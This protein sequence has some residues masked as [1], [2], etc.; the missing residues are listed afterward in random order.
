[1]DRFVQAYN[2]HHRHSEIGFHTPTDVHF[3]MTGHVED[4]RLAALQAAWDAHPER[5]GQRSLPK[6]LQVPEAAWINEPMKLEERE[7]MIA[8]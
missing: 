1:M 2:G 5:F 4:Q 6:K 8:V 7:E 3:G